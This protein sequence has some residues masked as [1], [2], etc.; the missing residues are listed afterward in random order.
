MY[1]RA[2]RRRASSMQVCAAP[3]DQDFTGSRLCKGS[4]S[5]PTVRGRDGVSHRVSGAISRSACHLRLLTQIH[6]CPPPHMHTVGANLCHPHTPPPHTCQNEFPSPRSPHGHV[7]APPSSTLSLAA[8]NR[9][10]SRS[11]LRLASAKRGSESSE[12]PRAS[13]T[14][15]ASIV[16]FKT[17]A[18]TSVPSVSAASDHSV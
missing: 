8:P 15:T 12:R 3:R 4:R 16:G 14:V 10:L 11:P 13:A 1:M 7:G 2:A 9:N 5:E 18:A 6:I 17:R